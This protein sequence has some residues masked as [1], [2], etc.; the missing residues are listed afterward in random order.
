MEMRSRC[1][2]FFLSHL[3]NYEIVRRFRRIRRQLPENHDSVFLLNTDAA[4]APEKLQGFESL[5]LENSEIAVQSF[6]RRMRETSNRVVPG[7]TDQ[8]LVAAAQKYPGYDYYWLV[9]YDVVFRG[10]WGRFFNTFAQVHCDLLGTNFVS[11]ECEPDWHWWP[12]FRAPADMSADGEVSWLKAFFPI[13]RIS[14]KAVDALALRLST[15]RWEGHMESVVPTLLYNS[16]YDVQDIGGDSFLTP[17]SRRGK[18]YTGRVEG[19]DS[20]LGSFRYRPAMNAPGQLS[21]L[22]Y[23]P[24]K[25]PERRLVLGAMYQLLSRLVYRW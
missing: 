13:M 20:E 23:H 2:V 11:Y 16:D 6:A 3:V 7:N 22:L 24:V 9:E 10:N 8:L 4:V 19:E 21:D 18:W 14:S 5:V 12:H 25:V 17:E 1:V 15:E